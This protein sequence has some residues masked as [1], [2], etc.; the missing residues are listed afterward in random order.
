MILANFECPGVVPSSIG[1]Q[2]SDDL[3]VNPQDSS[4][5][6]KSPPAVMVRA[7]TSASYVLRQSQ[8]A[9]SSVIDGTSYSASID[10]EPSL[11][12][13]VGD[14]RFPP[15]SRWKD[16]VLEVLVLMGVAL[17]GWIV[18]FAFNTSLFLPLRGPSS[19]DPSITACLSGGAL[20]PLGKILPVKDIICAIVL[21]RY[22][23]TIGLVAAG[24]QIFD[25]PMASRT[26]VVGVVSYTSVLTVAGILLTCVWPYPH[27]DP[28]FIT[29][30]ITSSLCLCVWATTLCMGIRHLLSPCAGI[31]FW[32]I[33]AM[34]STCYIAV[35]RITT[36]F[37]GHGFRAIFVAFFSV[38]LIKF[39][40][41]VAKY[42]FERMERISSTASGFLLFYL[43][44]GC[45]TFLR[46]AL[47]SRSLAIDLAGVILGT[48]GF[49][50]LTRIIFM[51]L[52]LCNFKRLVS[53]SRGDLAVRQLYIHLLSLLSKTVAE[54]VAFS[55]V[56]TFILFVDRRV[57]DVKIDVPVSVAVRSWV[58]QYAADV[59]MNV[60][61]FMGLFVVVPIT[62][63]R[64]LKKAFA[65]KLRWKIVAFV[66][67]IIL[68]SLSSLE[69]MIPVS[70]FVCE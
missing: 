68:S 14:F 56:L 31:L 59:G 47:A 40:E 8:S 39:V 46:R 23:T 1:S 6:V 66:L 42:S 29:N 27:D 13:N 67:M 34:I 55:Q 10:W 63:T 69:V 45:C 38:C 18:A 24:L 21:L 28:Y 22:F 50:L 15:L 58:G 11:E 4:S 44:C 26:F 5:S 65:S 16:A 12:L 62:I 43:Q 36:Y 30:A 20:T 7:F 33:V 60:L 9:R 41:M 51:V 37:I 53:C 49:E 48:S 19:F 35:A 70:N 3:P 57:L 2:A 17:V 32:V 61:F 52:C 25:I 54:Q 64:P